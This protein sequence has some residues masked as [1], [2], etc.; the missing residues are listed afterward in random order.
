MQESA[1]I[2]TAGTGT[3]GRVLIVVQIALSVVLLAAAGLFL[4]TLYELH[5]VDAGYRARGVLSVGVM[6]RN[7]RRGATDLAV[8]YPELT[9][10]MAA[11]PHVIS[12]A[13]MHGHPNSGGDPW[14][15]Q[16]R[17]AGTNGATIHADF[18]AVTPGVFRT[19]EIGLLRGRDFSW[20]DDAH[21]PRVAIVSRSFVEQLFPGQDPIGRMIEIPR[22]PTWPAAQIVGIAA[23]T[24]LN[25]LRR[26]SPP[27]I[28]VPAVQYGW[29]CDP[30][31]R[32]D[33]PVAAIAGSLRRTF[34][35]LGK[36]D[37]YRIEELSAFIDRSL[38]RERVI[39]MLAL[40]F[41]GLA[42]LLSAI[43]LYGLMAYNVTRRTREIGIRMALGAQQ[44]GVRW[45][46]LR[47]S[48]LL[49]LLGIAAG[50]PC[51]MAASRW[52][53]NLLFRV[54]ISDPAILAGICG[55]LL[56][57]AALATWLPA[58]RATRVDPMIALRHE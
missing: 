57:V 55:T 1:R 49:A 38:I 35:S 14:K 22:V 19:L 23:D 41:G 15:E 45:L 4:R 18:E 47:E 56:A 30:L 42:L 36:E 46:V 6:A 3:L 9:A 29:E 27:T 21:S 51:T 16:I 37:V 58:H 2:I 8:Y 10:R 34:G 26:H 25:D 53:G 20:R 43:G 13:L 12:V 54:S 39:A 52:I 11:L 32:T 7:Q 24:S 50:L 33:V 17:A 28:Y 5:T 31:V 44:Q 48:L 40:F